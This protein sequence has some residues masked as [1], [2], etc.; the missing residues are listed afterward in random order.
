MEINTTMSKPIHNKLYFYVFLVGAL[1]LGALVLWPMRDVI[2]VSWVVTT[3][4]R[5]IY[6][7][8][9]KKL[10]LS[11]GLASTISV[12]VVIF[13]VLI[14]IFVFVNL[15]VS[16]FKIFYH[17]INA[18]LQGGTSIY[19]VIVSAFDS[20]N[21][22]L[23]RIPFVE[24]RLSIENVKLL[25]QQNLT[26]LANF[27]LGHSLDV[28]VF[29]AQSFPL[30]IVFIY[31]IWYGFPDFDSV[32]GF[33]KKLSPLSEKL[34]DLYLERI[35][36]MIRGIA[37]GTFTIAL[38][39][40]AIAGLSFYIVGI[41]YVFFWTVCFFILCL[42]PL[43]AWFL[44]I[45]ATILMVMLGNYWQALV[46]MG[47]QVFFTSTIDNI[48]RPLLVPKEVVIHPAL[49]LLS[50]IGGIQVFGL[51]G[52]LYGPMIMV[53][54]MTTFEVYQKHFGSDEV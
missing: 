6:E 15:S 50:F 5:P 1:A 21:Q 46:I 7:F 18:F 40:S 43:G 2:L 48:L 44:T 19:G 41:P 42:L 13:A 33:I 31:L 11:R 32:I 8:F 47:I 12:L 28:G 38:V 17:D 53:I 25:L 54:A 37:K 34:D 51:W 30:L 39:Q 14:P 45:P 36:A 49:L 52:F 4:F 16:Q 3:L 35:T 29:F 10:K 23:A 24:Y 27:L 26:P 9:A 20:I 22:I